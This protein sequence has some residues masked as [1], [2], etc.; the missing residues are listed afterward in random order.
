MAYASCVRARV[1]SKEHWRDNTLTGILSI[2]G[3]E[4]QFK[5]RGHVA[6]A[7]NSQFR[8][9]DWKPSDGEEVI[10]D[11]DV[12]GGRVVVDHIEPWRPQEYELL[13]RH[14]D[15]VERAIAEIERAP[16][17]SKLLR[18][19]QHE[20]D[21]ADVRI[22]RWMRHAR[23]RDGRKERT[24]IVSAI[25]A[26]GEMRFCCRYREGGARVPANDVA[27]L[28]LL[29]AAAGIPTAAVETAR[30]PPKSTATTA[31]SRTDPNKWIPG[32]PYRPEGMPQQADPY[33]DDDFDPFGETAMSGPTYADDD[34]P[35]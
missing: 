28:P 2:D 22:V 10:I 32:K 20:D 24:A 14:G 3:V 21:G 16:E 25:V 9:V 27:V 15:I 34:I 12:S 4:H 23:A 31:A 26:D 7:V 1:L 11:G 35:F 33:A 18:H 17:M 5:T 29:A 13:G 19:R 8:D 30:T 6:K